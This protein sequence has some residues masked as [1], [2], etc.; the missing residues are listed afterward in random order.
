MNMYTIGVDVHTLGTHMTGAIHHKYN[1]CTQIFGKY[2]VGSQM[3]NV[4]NEKG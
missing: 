3:R 4:S 2:T 1:P